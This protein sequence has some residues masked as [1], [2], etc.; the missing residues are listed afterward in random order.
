[1]DNQSETFLN[2]IFQTFTIHITALLAD[3]L[4]T[5]GGSSTHNT[6]TYNI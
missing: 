6:Y 3:I 5:I 1:M 4:F 2:D